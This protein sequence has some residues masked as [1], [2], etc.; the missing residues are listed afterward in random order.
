MAK[1][2]SK[3]AT[4]QLRDAILRSGN[5]KQSAQETIGKTV[6][7]KQSQALAIAARR[8]ELRRTAH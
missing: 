4:K 1:V 7:K 5:V 2:E 8:R 6:D 3:Q